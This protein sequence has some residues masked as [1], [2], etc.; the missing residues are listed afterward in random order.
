MIIV[1]DVFKICWNCEEKS[2]KLVQ[3]T[4]PIMSSGFI[5]EVE[6]AAA[7]Q[8]RQAEWEKVRQPDEPLGK[9]TKISW[10]LWDVW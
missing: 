6:I 10:I 2:S 4:I 8:K 3:N 7:K 9:F 5:S 1:Y